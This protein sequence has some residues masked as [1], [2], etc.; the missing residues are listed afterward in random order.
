MSYI[1]LPSGAGARPSFY[2]IGAA[3]NLRTV[4]PSSV[5]ITGQLAETASGFYRWDSTS[6]VADNGT[7]VL[8]PND[9][10]APNPGRWVYQ[11][12]AVQTPE[13][14]DWT[15]EGVYSGAAVPVYLNAPRVVWLPAPRTLQ[16]ALL[17]RRTAGGAGSSA[18]QVYRNGNPVLTV[19]L[20]VTAAAGDYAAAQTTSFQVGQDVFGPLDVIDVQLTSVESFKAGPPPGPEGLRLLLVF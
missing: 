15:A 6:V 17:L 19:P 12:P 18:V 2:N 4:A 10:P 16:R 3:T 14:Y 8:R 9:V 11:P 13:P 7:T 5:L 20:A 1:T